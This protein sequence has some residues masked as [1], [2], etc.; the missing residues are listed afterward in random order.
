MQDR[1]MLHAPITLY[2]RPTPRG[3]GE[4]E[5]PPLSPRARRFRLAGSGVLALVCVALFVFAGLPVLADKNA[6]ALPVEHGLPWQFRYDGHTYRNSS[7]CAR[8]NVCGDTPN[9]V[10]LA[11]IAMR[12]HTPLVHVTTVP[13]LFG[14]GHAAFVP[15]YPP[16]AAGVSRCRQLILYVQDGNRYLMYGVHGGYSTCDRG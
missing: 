6:F 3:A 5:R 4:H 15:S 2:R 7:V 10:S 9:Y 1:D 12:G 16:D 11:T 13:T 8:R 14:P